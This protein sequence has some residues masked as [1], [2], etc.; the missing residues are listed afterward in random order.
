MKPNAA[1]LV[2]SFLIAPYVYA[3]DMSMSDYIEARNSPATKAYVTGL[4]EGL[5]FASHQ[6]ESLHGAPL[7]CAPPRLKLTTQNFIDI[8]EAERI[9]NPGKSSGPWPLVGVLLRGL[10]RTFPCK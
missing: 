10:V 6:A 8:I 2:G 1:F 3:V 4:G 5:D 9:V 7:F